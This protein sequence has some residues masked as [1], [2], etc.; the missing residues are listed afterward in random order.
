LGQLKEPLKSFY[1]GCAGDSTYP[2][3]RAHVCAMCSWKEPHYT[4]WR[5]NLWWWT[6]PLPEYNDSDPY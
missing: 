2:D 3:P 6:G 4:F 5:D 1:A